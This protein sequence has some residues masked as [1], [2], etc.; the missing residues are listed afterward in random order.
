MSG[1]VEVLLN[2]SPGI[3]RKQMVLVALANM[4]A[5]VVVEALCQL[6]VS[7]LHDMAKMVSAF[8]GMI[9]GEGMRRVA[10]M[11]AGLPDV[12]G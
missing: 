9:S 1:T 12:P 11:A 10:E 3:A 4:D 8:R 6:S 2:D 5:E 7:E